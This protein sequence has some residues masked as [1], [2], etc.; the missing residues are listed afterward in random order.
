MNVEQYSR[1]LR[2]KNEH[3]Q[4]EE[5][6]RSATQFANSRFKNGRFTSNE[7]SLENSKHF[8]NNCTALVQ[9]FRPGQPFPTQELKCFEQLNPKSILNYINSAYDGEE[10][11]WITREGSWGPYASAWGI[12]ATSSFLL[13]LQRA[14][15]SGVESVKD[16]ECFVIVIER[17]NKEVKRLLTEFIT[18]FVME[19]LH[20][21]SPKMA[22]FN[23]LYFV[24]TAILAIEECSAAFKNY[25]DWGL[26]GSVHDNIKQILDT[27]K[28]SYENH[29]FTIYTNISERL[30]SQL[31]FV[32]MRL[33]HH[34]D[35]SEIILALILMTDFAPPN[36]NPSEDIVKEAVDI[37]FSLQKSTGY[38]DSS[39]P[40]L[41]SMTGSVGCSSIELA[42]ALLS[43]QTL[44]PYVVDYQENFSRLYQF[45]ERSY[46]PKRPG[47]G[48][49]SELRRGSGVR[50]TWYGFMVYAFVRELSNLLRETA[51][52]ELLVGFMRRDVGKSIPFE[53]L[54][55]SNDF[56]NTLYRRLIQPRREMRDAITQEDHEAARRQASYSAIIFGPPGTGKTTVAASIAHALDWDLIEIGPG[57]FL[58]Q[59][60][61]GVFA[62]G[63]EI[64]SRLL[65]A[66]RTV[67]LFDELDEW[68]LERGTAED[69]I[70]RFLTTFMLPWLQRL[71]DK[72]EV[73]FLFAT[74]RVEAFDAAIKRN[75]RFD[76]IV[77][78]GPPD[79]PS[80]TKL[81]EK[82]LSDVDLG[83][84]PGCSPEAVAE[85]FGD[86][87]TLGDIIRGVENLK[88]RME[89]GWADDAL[90]KTGDTVKQSL[91]INEEDW[92]E[93][94]KGVQKYAPAN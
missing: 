19:H 74:N 8:I 21:R 50:E 62:Q 52:D 6:L 27:I 90:K 53:E 38:W 55:D 54:L 32:G 64:F 25:E 80:R 30:F 87:A 63:E 29:T 44:R 39:R 86:Q 85:E 77:P 83:S 4:A 31:A 65:L 33:D 22:D 9:I 16:E 71:R 36:L 72:S 66:D 45:L 59:G 26:D 23:H 82:L 35:E 88:E 91:T 56:K 48:W 49:S 43:S 51:G 46:D 84:F 70:S 20:E 17:I 81:I 37:V 68:V 15:K 13:F 73:I 12:L 18:P 14:S 47:R 58:K 28:A 2:L 3:L 93:F 24:Y 41:G 1:A 69:K 34:I 42:L 78:I 60:V 5:V 57:D 94:Q 76:A 89:Q 75:G 92:K 79:E 11:G 40:I 61:E 10:N 7:S 67:I